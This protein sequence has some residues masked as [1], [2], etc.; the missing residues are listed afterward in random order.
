MTQ[1]Q[2]FYWNRPQSS[3]HD[4][5]VVTCRVWY[6]EASQDVTR[7]YQG[8]TAR[9]VM[10]RR[11]EHSWRVNIAYKST[12]RLSLFITVNCIIARSCYT[13][14]SKVNWFISFGISWKQTCFPDVNLLLHYSETAIELYSIS[15]CKHCS[16]L[17]VQMKL[18]GSQRESED[19]PR[20]SD[21]PTPVIQPHFCFATCPCP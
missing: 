10:D 6:S 4:V 16:C 7:C 2:R 1:T 5:N 18:P 3:S 11:S 12:S 15:K 9:R 13:E 20:W 17:Q 14:K 21:M 19:Y 8:N